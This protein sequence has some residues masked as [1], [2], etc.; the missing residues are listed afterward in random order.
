MIR[1]LGY[2]TSV[3]LCVMLVNA[4][5]SYAEVSDEKLITWFTFDEGQ[6]R[7]VTDTAPQGESDDKSG[8][9]GDVAWDKSGV[10]GGSLRFPGKHG[11]FVFLPPGSKDIQANRSKLG[12]HSHVTFS[13]WFNAD[14]SKKADTVQ[15]LFETGGYHNN[16]NVFIYEGVLYVGA[17]GGYPTAHQPA[18]WMNTKE[19]LLTDV[20]WEMR[21]R[22]WH[23]FAFV[24]D[25]DEKPVAGGYRI[26]LDGELAVTGLGSVVEGHGARGGLGAANDEAIFPHKRNGWAELPSMP[27]VK[28][29]DGDRN[30]ESIGIYP[31]AGA[32]DDFRLYKRVLS[33][34]E[35][36][37]L[38]DEGREA[39]AAAKIDKP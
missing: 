18:Q 37:Q 17:I 25:A 30:P 16:I 39:L 38:H 23:H 11:S 2:S 27:R 9:K 29:T 31:F 1:I 5:A 32:I 36:K 7:G 3:A 35:I 24:I 10:H 22:Q 26:F 12:P 8:L 33:S 13:Y 34:E 15:T 19:N 14:E 28:D 21:D 20:Q 6:G 4:T